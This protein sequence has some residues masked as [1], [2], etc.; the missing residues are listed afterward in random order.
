MESSSVGYIPDTVPPNVLAIDYTFM[1]RGIVRIDWE[2][3]EP[4]TTQ[5][6]YGTTLAYGTKTPVHTLLVT[7]HSVVLSGLSDLTTYQYRVISKDLAGNTIISPNFTFV[8]DPEP[9]PAP[10]VIPSYSPSPSTNPY[11]SVSP[12]PS[13]TVSV[14]PV[15]TSQSAT[16]WNAVLMFFGFK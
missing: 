12:T 13:G 10:T 15:N 5:V 9:T 11:P 1:S 4:S 2:T 7:S 8:T 16:T 6:E 14:S 3:D